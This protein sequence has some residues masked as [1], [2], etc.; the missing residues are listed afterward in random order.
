MGALQVLADPRT[1]LAQGLHAIIVAEMVDNDG[2]EMLIRLAR[3]LGHTQ[4]ATRFN[5]ALD[6]EQRHLQMGRAWLSREVALEANREL[7]PKLCRGSRQDEHPFWLERGYLRAPVFLTPPG[8][9][10]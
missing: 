8:R 4:L 3:D 1:S 7:M 9:D 10:A 2:W 6:H 5:T